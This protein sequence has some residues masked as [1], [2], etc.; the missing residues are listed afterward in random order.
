MHSGRQPGMSRWQS[1]GA[2]QEWAYAVYRFARLELEGE[3]ASLSD[4]PC[5][6]MKTQNGSVQL[7][8]LL[9][10]LSF[11]MKVYEE[12]I[13]RSISPKDDVEARC[14]ADVWLLHDVEA[15]A[16][17]NDGYHQSWYLFL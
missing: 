12:E 13:Q 5:E 1:F 14:S 17:S 11:R 3:T 15:D 6:T 16:V 9:L 8:N 7:L 10:G 4:G 2:A